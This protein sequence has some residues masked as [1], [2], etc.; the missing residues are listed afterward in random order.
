MSGPY[1]IASEA[2]YDDRALCH[3]LGLKAGAI[4]RARRGG[5]LKSTRRGGKVLYLGAWV[6]AWLTREVEPI[7]A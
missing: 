7:C 3:S 6:M 4:E 1:T 5:E 2:W